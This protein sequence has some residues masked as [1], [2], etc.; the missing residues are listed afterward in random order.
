MFTPIEDPTDPRYMPSIVFSTDT[1][2]DFDTLLSVLGNM[3]GAGRGWSVTLHLHADD[4]VGR[5]GWVDYDHPASGVNIVLR[6]WDTDE[7]VHVVPLVAVKHI[8]ID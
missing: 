1:G 6:H 7:V 5:S 8:Q 4:G 3:N 2:A